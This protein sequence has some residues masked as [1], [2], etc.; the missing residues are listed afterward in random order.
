MLQDAAVVDGDRVLDS[1]ERML[2]EGTA[3]E[4]CHVHYAAHGCFAVRVERGVSA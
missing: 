3:A 2:G 4:Y 1:L